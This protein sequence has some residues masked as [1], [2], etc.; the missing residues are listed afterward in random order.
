MSDRLPGI[1][2]RVTHWRRLDAAFRS[3]F[4]VGCTVALVLL[5]SA[6]LDLPAQ[7]ELQPATALACVFFWSLHRPESMPPLAVFAIGLLCDLLGLAPV[8]STVVALLL[9]H[10][11]VLRARRVLVR[12]EL[13]VVWLAFVG[14]AAGVAALQW[15]LTCLLTWHL[16][17]PEPAVFEAMVSAGLYPALA[18]VFAQAHR[19]LADP[20]QA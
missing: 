6:P 17:S 15:T 10:G 7:A 2:P 20:E 18:T 8:G 19:G 1:R 9:A 4:P 12:L 14:V 16:L 13:A 3:I 5:L 11:L